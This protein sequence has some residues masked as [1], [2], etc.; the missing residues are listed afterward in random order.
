MES[1]DACSVAGLDEFTRI[2]HIALV[3]P[4]AQF[5]A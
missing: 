2:Q 1:T 3:A 5:T 4:Q